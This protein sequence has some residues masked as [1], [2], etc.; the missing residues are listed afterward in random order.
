MNIY[1]FKVLNVDDKT[2]TSL[3]HFKDQ[4]LLITIT[5][6]NGLFS[7]KYKELNEL[8][9]KYHSQGFNILD[10]PCNQFSRSA[11][12]TSAQINKN[13]LQKY[14]TNF[15]RFAKI[16]S[17][18]EAAI[19]LFRY[20]NLVQPFTGLNKDSDNGK[21][22]HETLLTKD[23]EYESKGGIL[24]EFTQFLINRQGEVIARFEPDA[25][26]EDISSKIESLI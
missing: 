1:D 6:P 15:P 4:I 21:L 10:F 16:I 24:W 12:G 23:P 9:T 11:R 20:L 18:G 25:T 14:H 22:L 7:H 19:P 26:L 17:Y 2:F 13:V 8:Y 5:S 3:A